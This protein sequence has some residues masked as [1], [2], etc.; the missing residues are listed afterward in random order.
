MN[1]CMHLEMSKT[2]LS[3][4]YNLFVSF[5]PHVKQIFFGFL[6]NHFFFFFF[7]FLILW[8]FLI[9]SK[10][11]YIYIKQNRT[12][13]AEIKMISFFVFCFLKK[14]LPKSKQ[15]KKQTFKNGSI[16]FLKNI[17]LFIYLLLSGKIFVFTF[18]DDH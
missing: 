13:K 7:P 5:R 1:A 15:Q 12:E 14:F 8:G 18:V 10:V 11:I 16:L 9:S 4:L 2:N 17:Y 3:I 6:N